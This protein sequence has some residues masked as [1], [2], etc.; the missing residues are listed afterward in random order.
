MPNPTRP[1]PSRVRR[2][3]VA[4]IDAYERFYVYLAAIFIA[5]LVACNLI[6]LKFFRWETPIEG[7]VFVQSVGILAYP[8]TFLVTDILS[9]A[10]GSKRAN[11]VVTAGFIA[12]LFV[13]GLVY[14]SDRTSAVASSPLSDA[15]FHKTFGLFGVGVAASMV[16]YL[17][18]QYIDI[19]L[20]RFWRKLT[21]GKHLWVRNNFSTMLSQVVDTA[22]V[23]GLLC[24]FGA[25]P[26]SKFTL[27]FVNGVIFK[28]IVALLDTPFFYA[29][30]AWLRKRFPEQV[31]AI[32]N[33]ETF[34]TDE[35]AAGLT[36]ATDLETP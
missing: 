4:T 36:V 5:A 23:V 27:L 31:E 15:E 26:W 20:F 17:A 34:E 35:Q 10:Y 19:R 16:A 6:F 21:K 25:L 28:W 8:V 18:A 1:A 13:L 14:I 3:S 24:A 2:T 12:S 9:E 22:S 7:L 33:L 11:A 29:A 30:S 32:H